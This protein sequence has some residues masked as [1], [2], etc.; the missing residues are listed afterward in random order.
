VTYGGGLFKSRADVFSFSPA[1]QLFT[2]LAGDNGPAFGISPLYIGLGN[3]QGAASP[4]PGSRQSHTCWFARGLFYIFG[5]ACGQRSESERVHR[6]VKAIL[7][8]NGD[9]ALRTC[10]DACRWIGGRGAW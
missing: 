8:V 10:V 2:W 1:S 7:T 4:S 9:C 6:I 5:Q 3:S